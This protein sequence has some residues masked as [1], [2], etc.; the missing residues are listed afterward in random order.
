VSNY[1]TYQ[2]A[3]SFLREGKLVIENHTAAN[4]V[5]KAVKKQ[6]SDDSR[7]DNSLNVCTFVLGNVC[8]GPSLM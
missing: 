8:V 2:T 7:E 3:Y 4:Q 5:T 6:A 1:K